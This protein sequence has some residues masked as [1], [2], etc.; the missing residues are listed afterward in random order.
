MLPTAKGNLGV[1]CR[2][3]TMGQEAARQ[4]PMLNL[5]E[6]VERYCKLSGKFCVPVPLAGF[7][8]GVE[9][10]TAVFTSLDED[11][12]I[13]RFFHF[14]KVAGKCFEVSGERVTHIAI[15]EGIKT[16]L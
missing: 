13:S 7:D 5:K 2:P 15:E 14:T 12:H 11:Y 4:S 16:L 9:E 1:H 6:V 8:L 3:E 10:T